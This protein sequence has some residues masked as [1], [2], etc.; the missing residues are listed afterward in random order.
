MSND[1]QPVKRGKLSRKKRKP[2]THVAE[3]IGLKDPPDKTAADVNLDKDVDT[4]GD[5]RI[6]PTQLC[7]QQENKKSEQT[8][9]RDLLVDNTKYSN[10]DYNSSLNNGV[11][12]S[13]IKDEKL[14]AICHKLVAK[15]EHSSHV[16]V[17]LK[18]NFKRK[19]N[20][21]STKPGIVSVNV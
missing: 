3:T 12:T 19:G 15:D 18:T 9:R 10:V 14:C 21:N 20:L 6:G 4:N 2:V 5:Q 17:C 16:R 13:P 8:P 11:K 1:T 7:T